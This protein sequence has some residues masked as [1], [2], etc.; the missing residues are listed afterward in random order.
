MCVLWRCVSGASLS[1]PT[2]WSECVCV[3]LSVCEWVEPIL[4][5]SIRLWRVHTEF[6]CYDTA[7]PHLSAPLC[8]SCGSNQ[9]QQGSFFFFSLNCEE[10]N[11]LISERI[12]A[13]W[14]VRGLLRENYRAML[15][16]F[17]LCIISHSLIHFPT[18]AAYDAATLPLLF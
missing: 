15:P 12:N 7:E 16:F 17:F 9:M 4:H 18:S 1:L 10:R 3:C 5:L 6:I 13:L 2:A 14:Q 8:T 11:F